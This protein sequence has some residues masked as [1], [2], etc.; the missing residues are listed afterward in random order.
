MWNLDGFRCCRQPRE[1]K[2]ATSSRSLAVVVSARP[3]SK[4]SPCRCARGDRDRHQSIE[5][6]P[7]AQDWRH[8]RFHDDA[9]AA[10]TILPDLTWGKNCDVV[11][12][13]VGEAT[14]EI[15]E[16]ARSILAK[17]ESSCCEHRGVDTASIDLNLFMFS[18]MNQEIRGTVFVPRA[19]ITDS[20][21]LRLH[22]EGKFMIDELVTQEY[23]LDEVQKGY[24]DLEAARTSASHSFLIVD[25]LFAS[26]A[27]SDRQDL[28][29][30][31]R[32]C[33][34]R[35]NPTHEARPRET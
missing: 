17:A 21:L 8:A 15:V 29:V 28:F 3:Q 18:M 4:S 23:S 24:D 14:S 33:V 34:I 30:S 20:R 12:I 31:T 5:D 26:V 10:F 7:R 1:V 2:R 13:T 32:R 16:Q 19:A 25:S 35:G 11:I 6:R 9:G 27:R 22:H